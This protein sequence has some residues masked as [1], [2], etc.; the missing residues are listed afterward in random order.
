MDEEVSTANVVGGESTTP[1]EVSQILGLS[2]PET[3]AE[4]PEAPEPETPEEPAAPV[5]PEAPV[6]PVAPVV[7]TPAEPETPEE[8]PEAPSFALE[9]EDASGNKLT[10]NPGDNLEEVLQDFEPKTNGQIFQIIKDVMKME[11]AKEAYD[12]QQADDAVVAERAEAVANIQSGWDKEIEA[13]RGEKRLGVPAD[14][15]NPEDKANQR[16]QQVYK[17][18][19]ETN[20]KRIAE[21][22]EPIR[23][24]ED[25]LD[26][27]E[28]QERRDAE[29]EAAKKAKEDAKRRG[30]LVGGGSAPGTPS[31]GA[32]RSGSARTAEEALRNAGLR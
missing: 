6:E 5:E 7:E 23:S 20:E 13:L 22:R 28:L 1:E 18:M 32:Y 27:I 9:V 14:P 15:N 3:V 21:G 2:A 26:K 29:T 17:F 8:A 19:A 30:G 31:S 11:A 16:V 25:A 4:E 24:L 12:A 10:V